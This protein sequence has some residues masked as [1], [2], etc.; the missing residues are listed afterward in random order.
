[1]EVEVIK[2]KKRKRTVSARVVAKK[3]LEVRVPQEMKKTHIEDHVRYLKRKVEKGL[4]KKIGD[5]QKYLDARGEY[6]NQTYF[7]GQLRFNIKFVSNQNVVFGS[8]SPKR[9]VVRVSSRLMD[10]PEWVRDYVLIHELA[11]L[12]EPNHSDAFWELVNQYRLSE[13]ARGYLKAY[14]ENPR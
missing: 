3:V 12:V 9:R 1:M 6:L 13:R 5:H 2:S 4:K 7:A 10:V 11:H 8:T 14:S